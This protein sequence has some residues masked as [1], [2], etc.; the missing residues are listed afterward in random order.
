MPMST[1]GIGTIL[2]GY[3]ERLVGSPL[4]SRPRS[5]LDSIMEVSARTTFTRAKCN[6]GGACKTLVNTSSVGLSGPNFF[7]LR[8]SVT[9]AVAP[10]MFD[11]SVSG[12]AHA[13]R[14][15]VR[16]RDIF[17]ISPLCLDCCIDE[18]IQ[19]IAR[20]DLEFRVHANATSDL[21]IGPISIPAGSSGLLVK[22]QKDVFTYRHFPNRAEI[23]ATWI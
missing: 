10:L 21:S 18:W 13:V 8:A 20:V 5:T 19:G 9:T 15:P 4:D 1:M 12:T 6:S 14:D 22:Y 7:R 16:G 3:F 11:L 23:V 2:S 17:S